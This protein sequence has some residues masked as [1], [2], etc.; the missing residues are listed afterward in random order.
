[1]LNV[2]LITNTL[3]ELQRRHDA[4]PNRNYANYTNYY[5]PNAERLGKNNLSYNF[6]VGYGLGLESSLNSNQFVFAV[7]ISKTATFETLYSNYSSSTQVMFP[8]DLYDKQYGLTAIFNLHASL[9]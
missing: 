9:F 1:M 3:D 7:R 2:P 8:N 5:N 6:A 4:N